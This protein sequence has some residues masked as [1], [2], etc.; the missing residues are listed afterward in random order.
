MALLLMQM[1]NFTSQSTRAYLKVL[2]L[3]KYPG[4]PAALGTREQLGE[5]FR[6]LAILELVKQEQWE[7]KIKSVGK[8]R[9]DLRPSY[10]GTIADACDKTA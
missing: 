1:K 2:T 7:K 5:C 4:N 8:L 6:Q 3:V 9:P 10:E